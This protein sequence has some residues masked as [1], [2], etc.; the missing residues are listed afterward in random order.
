M[1][2]NSMVKAY[3]GGVWKFTQTPAMRQMTPK[4]LADLEKDTVKQE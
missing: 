2:Q 3:N 4:N 1:L